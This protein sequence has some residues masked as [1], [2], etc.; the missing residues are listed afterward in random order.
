MGSLTYELFEVLSLSARYLFSF[1]GILIA[2]RAFHWLFSDSR[3]S[4]RAAKHPLSDAVGEFVVISGNRDLPEGQSILVPWEGTLGSV[5]SC[6]IFIPDTAIHRNHLFFSYVP[7]SGLC[8]RPQ[9]VNEILV[10]SLPVS[11]AAT[12]KDLLLSQGDYLQAGDTVLR[13]HLFSEPPPFSDSWQETSSSVSWGP[14]VMPESGSLG[15]DSREDVADPPMPFGSPEALMN[16]PVPPAVFPP[17]EKL[18]AHSGSAAAPGEFS[19][20]P[21]TAPESVNPFERSSIPDPD[22]G[23]SAAES[24]RASSR[25]RQKWEADW[26]E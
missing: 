12:G 9:H 4:R 11:P 10:N 5:R 22:P 15:N 19:P 8:I 13:L 24:P 16:Q 21:D 1:M 2:L 7:G 3:A 23:D 14:S 26:S 6:D 25:R 18:P 17:E 20:S